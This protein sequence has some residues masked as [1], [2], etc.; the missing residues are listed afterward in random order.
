MSPPRQLLLAVLFSLGVSAPAAAQGPT[1]TGLQAEWRAGQTFITWRELSAPGKR[2]RVYRAEE[3]LL[4]SADLARADLLGEVDDESSR[5]QGRSLASVSEHNWVIAPGGAQLASDQGLFVYTVE[6]H[7]PAHPRLRDRALDPRAWYAVTSV[8]A[9][10]ENRTIAPGANASATGV[11]EWPAPPE[12]VLQSSGPDG[13]LYAHWVG[14]RDTPYQR[15]LA[16]WP[17]RGFNFLLQRGSAPGKHGLLLGLHAAGQTYS[18]GWPHRF[19][20]PSDVD[21][22]KPSDLVPYTSWSFWFGAQE[23]LPGVPGAH[24]RVWNFTQQRLAWT[25]DAAAALLGDRHDPERVY[26]VGGSMGA[27]GGMG[28][29][30]EY[31]ERFA[32]ALLRNGLYD[33]TATDYRNP[34]AFER[35]FGSLSLDLSTRDGLPILAR[36][37]ASFMAAREPARDWPVIRTINGRN[38]ETVGWMSAVRMMRGLAAAARPAVHYFD[39]RTHN[40]NGDWQPLERALIGRTCQVRRDRPSLRFDAF[41]LDD[42]PGDGT[43]TD[44][45]LVGAVNAYLDYDPASASSSETRL[46]FEVFLRDVGVLD[47][48]PG[49]AAS[50]VLTPCR[51]GA[52]RPL[53]G[54][55]V[56]FTQL[57][58]GRLVD[59]HLLFADAYGRVRT[60]AVRLDHSNRACRFE[61]GTPATRAELFLGAAP[62]AGEGAQVVLRGTPGAPWALFLRLAFPRA[63]AGFSLV[64]QGVLDERGLA[65]LTPAVP[66]MTPAGSTLAA[67]ALIGGR[68]SPLVTVTTQSD[69]RTPKA[70]LGPR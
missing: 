7:L 67:R 65:D 62:F 31:P 30:S 59:E 23:D 17:S 19:E 5:N 61:R 64:L 42:E 16:P 26:V 2:Y 13:Q 41:S 35:L 36:T 6:G 4:S 39:Q 43:R 24:T 27:I 44:G 58:E 69:L 25:L 3:P 53:P 38:D 15:A 68:F 34:G 45:D 20:V 54:E 49:G 37:D 47:D 32:A 28:L 63:P 51:T 10:I 18:D 1:V 22:L 29:L 12:P 60:P 57:A 9:G 21:L 33:L 56:H 46:D 55:A 70:P 14:N 50:V 40:P 66:R 52:F 8:Q 48:S 11:R